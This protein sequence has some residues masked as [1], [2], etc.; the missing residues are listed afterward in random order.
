M[1]AGAKTKQLRA[2]HAFVA[3]AR[4]RKEVR[5][6]VEMLA[7]ESD[8]GPRK[9]NGPK[10]HEAVTDAYGKL[11]ISL[12]TVQNIIRQLPDLGEPW[13]FAQFDA[14]DA[15]LVL[16]VAAVVDYKSKGARQVSFG[17]AEWICRVLKAAPDMP[18]YAAFQVAGFYFRRAEIGRLENPDLDGL[19]AYAPWRSESAWT[20]YQEAV[21][22][23]WLPIVAVRWTHQDTY[24]DMLKVL[25]DEGGNGNES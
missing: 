14:D 16:P 22:A 7:W 4:V 5:E 15:A 18:P 3:G 9:A 11:A 12:K 8:G 24:S 20:R 1:A 17:E 25:K 2:T 19:L 10:I 23:M 21:V 6:A 13:R